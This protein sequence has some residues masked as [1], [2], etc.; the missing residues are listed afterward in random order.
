MSLPSDFLVDL[1]SV[2]EAPAMKLIY[3]CGNCINN[4]HMSCQR[5]G[6]AKKGRR[7]GDACAQRVN[8][9]IASNRLAL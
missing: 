2:A 9:L 8:A 3:M 6:T 5:G 1:K 7:W 4:A